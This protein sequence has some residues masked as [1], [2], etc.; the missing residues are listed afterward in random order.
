MGQLQI[1]RHLRFVA[2]IALVWAYPALA[3]QNLAQQTLAFTH[4]TIID[5]PNSIPRADQTVVIRGNR[6]VAVGSSRSTRI[7]AGAR[8][9]E[10]GGKFIIPGLW[11]MHVHTDAPA[12]RELL[13]L[14]VANG[15]TGVR[16]MAGDWTTVKTFREDIAQGRLAGPRILAS[17]PY[18]E[19]GDV[20]IPHILTR[21]PDEARAGVDS[22]VR[23][24]VDFVKVHGQLMRDSYFAIA[25]RARERGIPFAGHVPHIVG[26]AAASDSGQ[27]SLL[28]RAQ[29]LNHSHFGRAL[30]FKAR[31]AVA[32]RWTLPPST[33]ASCRIRHG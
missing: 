8:V 11:D 30:P 32:H 24:G 6:I 5:G 9:V 20:P 19:G 14:Y 3:Q 29:L 22:L 16:D 25:R 18:L 7:P 31:S 1:S 33:R 17:G 13:A 15:V 26:A 12:G 21:N 10:G 23:L 2:L 4:V 28:F 27:R